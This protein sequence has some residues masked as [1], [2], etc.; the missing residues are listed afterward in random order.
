MSSFEI[1][2]ALS[3][4]HYVVERDMW[5]GSRS[6]FF[7]QGDRFVACSHQSMKKFPNVSKEMKSVAKGLKRAEAWL[8]FGIRANSEKT[9]EGFHKLNR[10]F[11]HLVTTWGVTDNVCLPNVTFR[12]IDSRCARS[13]LGSKRLRIAGNTKRLL[14]W[15][16]ER[17]AM[18]E[19]WLPPPTIKKNT[20]EKRKLPM[21]RSSGTRVC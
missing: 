17:L 11:S 15:T 20:P 5:Y 8:P 21:C 4:E 6:K 10:I 19:L 14:T 7:K 2:C 12:T 18:W 3:R 9:P 1:Q 16:T 13:L